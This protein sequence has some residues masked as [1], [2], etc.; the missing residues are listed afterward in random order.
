MWKSLELGSR[1]AFRWR[2]L[3]LTPGLEHLVLWGQELKNEFHAAS[4]G[5]SDGL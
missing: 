1:G 4:Q 5:D 2:F 3:N